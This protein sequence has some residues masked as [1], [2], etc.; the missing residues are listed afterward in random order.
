[1]LNQKISNTDNQ[2]T[3]NRDVLGEPPHDQSSN[4]GSPNY[5]QL[6]EAFGTTRLKA[7]LLAFLILI[8]IPVSILAGGLGGYYFGRTVVVDEGGKQVSLKQSLQVEE[9]SATI[10]ATQKVS[11]SVVS[12]VGRGVVKD[13]FGL[14]PEQNSGTGF[15]ITADGLIATNKHVV[16]KEDLEYTVILNS[17]KQ[18]PAKIVSKDPSFDLAIL[19]VEAEN[20]PVVKLGSSD[21]LK[22]GEK[23]IA[24]GNASGQLQNTVT[25][26]VISALNRSI[27]ASDG[28]LNNAVQLE[29]LLQTD[30][31]INP[32][33][34]GGPLVNLAGQ[35]VGVNTATEIGSQNIGF[36][37]P[38]DE[39]K[40]A[41]E[42]VIDSGK[43]IRPLLGVRFV[44]LNEDLA[45]LN[46]IPV[47]SGAYI[48]AAEGV[49]AVVK[50]SPAE[51]LGIQRGDI[52]TKLNNEEIKADHSLA[53]IMRKFRPKDEI[54]VTW[55]HDGQ[56]KTAKTTLNDFSE[57]KTQ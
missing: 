32:G 38:I 25:V 53:A 41:I 18:L 29:G 49:P 42:S 20:L 26:G 6:K 15:I 13:F 51:E 8:V 36:A 10:D 46:N 21:S 54:T 33:N 28:S 23:V 50:G 56:E 55:L 37:I 47:S 7:K 3:D 40:V 4:E 5:K 43:I 24:I 57:T 52:I 19:K 11:P 12:I 34:S 22:V 30:A 14:R 35:V 16:A 27:Q 9:N 17:G 1:M 39:A 48:I 2:S 31:A 45:K 44:N